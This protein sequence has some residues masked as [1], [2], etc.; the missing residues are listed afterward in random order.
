MKSKNP[1]VKFL[2]TEKALQTFKLSLM[3]R[4]PKKASMNPLFLKA[5]M[6]LFQGLPVRLN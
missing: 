6:G 1:K 4:P 2:L 5:H 3:G